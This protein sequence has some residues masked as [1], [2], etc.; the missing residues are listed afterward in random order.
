MVKNA[1]VVPYNT[2]SMDDPS[3]SVKEGRGALKD[4][5]QVGY[6]ASESTRCISRTVEYALNDYA[7]SVVASGEAPGDVQKYLSRSAGWQLIWNPNITAHGFSGF[8]APR[9][10]NGTWDDAGY[11]PG[12]LW[13]MRMEFNQL[14]GCPL[15]IQFHRAH[16]H[17]KPHREDGRKC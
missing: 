12:A 11:N 9:F 7:L 2:Y 16:G 15:G 8:L 4:W 17:G 5:L 10:L 6:V 14:R 1:E 3:A 13:W